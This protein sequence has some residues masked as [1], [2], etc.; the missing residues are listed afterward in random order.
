MLFGRSKVLFNA[1]DLIHPRS[2][3][4]IRKKFEGSSNASG[5]SG[6]NL[7]GHIATVIGG[8]GFMGTHITT[9]LVDSG[10]QCVVPKRQ[11]HDRRH[12]LSLPNVMVTV[13]EWDPRVESEYERV[14]RLSNY[15]VYSC[16]TWLA[17]HPVY[18]LYDRHY[19]IG[20]VHSQ[21]PR[22]AARMAR[23][24]DLERF[25]YVSALNASPDSES[26]IL[27]RMYETEVAVREEFPE[28]TIIRPSVTFGPNDL[29][30]NFIANR[31]TWSWWTT[32]GFPLVD[33]WQQLHAPVHGGDVGRAIALALKMEHT[34]GQTI[35]LTG[36]IVYQ[37][38]D[39]IR[40]VHDMIGR[41]YH[42]MPM[43]KKEFLTY[44]RFH[45]YWRRGARS[46]LCQFGHEWA[47]WL[48]MDWVADPKSTALTFADLGLAPEDLTILE[49]VSY[50]W[51]SALK[52]KL[53]RNTWDTY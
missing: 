53:I 42:P 11:S 35:E 29:Y 31:A 37:Y 41:E 17:P 21:M 43:S 19:G 40:W 10:V 6:C 25:I 16:G 8:G 46:N 9:Q 13:P 5:R 24:L 49:N 22:M 44:A 2:A 52:E 39:L 45:G 38:A 4:E 36:P 20:A 32:P 48:T 27:R 23:K 34:I 26:E 50:S 12:L 28:A 51:L 1:V 7:T 33:G 47:K 30:T 18:R 14:L 3:R 15:A